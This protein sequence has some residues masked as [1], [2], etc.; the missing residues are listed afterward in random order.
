[1]H[2]ACAQ[3]CPEA[4]EDMSMTL[5]ETQTLAD[6]ER[7]VRT[8]RQRR[9]ANVMYKFRCFVDDET[10]ADAE[11]ACYT[12]A[13]SCMVPICDASVRSERIET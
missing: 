10:E 1:M 7:T 12:R 9:A 5:R 2:I 3:T 6:R 8:K 11:N 4:W 13:R